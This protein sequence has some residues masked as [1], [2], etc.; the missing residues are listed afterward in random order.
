MKIRQKLTSLA[1]AL[2]V[3]FSLAAA[4]GAAETR[5]EIRAE[6]RGD[7]TIACSGDVQTMLDAA[8]EPVCPISYR[9]T[10]YVPIRAAAGMLGLAVDWDQAARTV[11][12]TDWPAVRSGP[13]QP[14]ASGG[15]EAVTAYIDRGVTVRYNGEPQIML[16]AGG[17]QVY[18]IIYNDTTYLPI[19][20]LGSMLG[21]PVDWDGET[22]TVLLDCPD[23]LAG[24]ETGN[25]AQV[26]GEGHI[27]ADWAEI[28]WSRADS[29]YVRVKWTKQLGKSASCGLYWTEKNQLKSYGWVRLPFDR[30][31][32][33]PLLHGSREY[34]VSLSMS[35]NADDFAGKTDEEID[36]FWRDSLQA[37]FPAEI[38]D[39]DA[40]WRL[41][42]IDIDW[43]NAPLTCAKALE[44]TEDCG[45]DA[46]KIAAVFRYVSQTIQYDYALAEEIMEYNNSRH[47]G[48][49]KDGAREY[50]VL[51]DILTSRSG[52]CEDYAK[53]TVGMLRSLG[54]PCKVAGGTATNS[55]GESGPHAWVLVK[56]GTGELDVQA[57]GAGTEGDWYR[58]DPTFFG[59]S[60]E[61]DQTWKTTTNDS[62][63]S[64]EEYW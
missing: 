5:E 8:G 56:P 59:T 55:R 63:Y 41:S 32:T 16:D 62:N 30:W 10:T 17:E 35:Y 47:K 43:E 24:F 50:L 3:I 25:G 27:G 39:P 18:P 52:V 40:V 9:G 21:I 4:A 26:L 11:I 51:D 31:V 6:L 61:P 19:R 37:R 58:L 49:F 48:L 20:A 22:R 1:L 2:A 7:V 14:A 34:A 15:A 54:V 60:R 36:V 42:T 64:A 29:G 38:S 57:L 46:E 28:D 53:L 45:T 33:L 23:R 44:I 13:D 12:L